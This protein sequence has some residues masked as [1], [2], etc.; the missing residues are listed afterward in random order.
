MEA[1][2]VSKL[3]IHEQMD[4]RLLL[5]TEKYRIKKHFTRREKVVHGC[6]HLV[7]LIFRT[8]S[9]TQ[10]KF[11][12]WKTCHQIQSCLSY[13]ASKILIQF[14]NLLTMHPLNFKEF[15]HASILHSTNEYDKFFV[16]LT[17]RNGLHAE[18]TSKYC[19]INKA[20]LLSRISTC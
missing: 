10:L 14:W 16:K 7:A 6:N 17:F 19:R 11:L 18:M 9:R 12:K 2:I 5:L 8:S 15:S 4:I 1:A 20:V 13:E 3:F